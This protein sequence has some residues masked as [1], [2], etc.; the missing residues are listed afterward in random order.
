MTA[1]AAEQLKRIDRTVTAFLDEWT[2]RT[3]RRHV[4]GDSLSQLE[5]IVEDSGRI[6]PSLAARLENLSEWLEQHGDV[7]VD[8]G[9]RRA[10]LEVLVN[11]AERLVQLRADGPVSD[12]EQVQLEQLVDRLVGLIRRG[13]L[14]LGL[15]YTPAGLMESPAGGRQES[16]RARRSLLARL[17]GFEDVKAAYTQALDFQKDR[18]AYFYQEDAH[19]LS[20]LDYQLKNL[21]ARPNP[22][23]EFFAACLI[24]FLSMHNYQVAPYLTRFR[25]VVGEVVEPWGEPAP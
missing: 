20:V 6:Y 8:H 15:E 7:V 25:K 14:E 2:A 12:A 11:A 18:L 19:L 9:V 23:D 16:Q 10:E 1:S 5:Q 3:K 21:E 13:S 4:V 22:D 17:Q 24:S